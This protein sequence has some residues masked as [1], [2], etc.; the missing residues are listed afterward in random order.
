MGYQRKRPGLYGG[1][2]WKELVSYGHQ[3]VAIDMINLPSIISIDP[4]K[5]E[6]IPVKRKSSGFALSW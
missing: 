4:A 2:Q 1:S 5:S 6:V 3:N